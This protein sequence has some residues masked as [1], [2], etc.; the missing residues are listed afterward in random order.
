MYV[1]HIS[2]IKAGIWDRNE[3]N[4]YALPYKNNT[5]SNVTGGYYLYVPA[6]VQGVILRT[7]LY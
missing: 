4:M 7:P 1:G 5:Q 6:L 2:I 3:K